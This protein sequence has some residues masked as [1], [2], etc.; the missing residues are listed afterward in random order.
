MS[1]PDF[2]IGGYEDSL[3]GLKRCEDCG[4]VACYVDYK[5]PDHA[6]YDSFYCVPCGKKREVPPVR[7]LEAEA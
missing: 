4:K 1:D 3:D 6:Y 2:P 5:N 7:E